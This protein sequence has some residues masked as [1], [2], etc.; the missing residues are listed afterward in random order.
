MGRGRRRREAGGGPV[1]DD[2]AL[3]GRSQGRWR[4]GGGRKREVSAD[5]RVESGRSGR[6]GAEV[7]LRS[8]SAI[9]DRR[10]GAREGAEER[11]SGKDGSPSPTP[12]RKAV[13]WA[14][15]RTAAAGTITRPRA[16]ASCCEC[17]G[18]GPGGGGGGSSRVAVKNVSH[19]RGSGEG[20]K[21]RGPELH[22]RVGPGL[23][24]AAAGPRHAA[25]G[26]SYCPGPGACGAASAEPSGAEGAPLAGPRGA[27]PE[28]GRGRGADP[29]R[30]GAERAS[31]TCIPSGAEPG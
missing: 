19:E 12:E 4:E 7:R 5:V 11:G 18:R 29:E 17:K 20:A 21:A 8:L 1:S 23:L 26:A 25:P 2:V 15:Q 22:P 9:V 30:A 14:P 6:L 3:Q 27:D 28:R 13:V 10:S 31:R 24:P 16:A